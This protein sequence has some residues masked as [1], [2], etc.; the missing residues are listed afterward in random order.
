MT[1]ENWFWLVAVALLGG[2]IGSFL[3]VVIYRLARG[4][5]VGRPAR[6]FCPGCHATIAWYDNIPLFSY[7][8]LGGR[9][10]RCGMVISA[11]YPLVEGLTI[12]LFLLMY[13]TFFLGPAR[14]GFTTLRDDWPIFLAHLVLIA[15]LLVTAAIDME[16]YWIDVTVTYVVVGAGILLHG[17]WTPFR[18]AVIPRPGPTTAAVAAA[19]ALGL[20]LA[21]LWSRR[22]PHAPGSEIAEDQEEHDSLSEPSAPVQNRRTSL[23]CAS[24]MVIVIAVWF[25]LL[26]V[27]PHGA[28]DPG[29]FAIRAVLAIA[30]AFSLMVAAGMTPTE[31]DREIIEAINEER[32]TARRMVLLEMAWLLPAIVLGVVACIVVARTAAGAE[33]WQRALNWTPRN[34]A[35]R[36]VLGVTTALGGFIVAGAVAWGV[37]I[38]F[39]LVLGKE[40]FGMGDVHLMAAA[41]AVAGWPVVVAGFFLA[42]PLA[43]AAVL[44]WLIRKRSRAVWYGPWLGLGI[45]IAIVAYE[46]IAERAR[47]SIEVILWLFG[48]GGR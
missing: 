15:G 24:L 19:A 26:A 30:A 7:L 29:G 32:I 38:F 2:C 46:P 42:A 17:L 33:L 20:L 6:S 5:S 23:A 28:A 21:V 25:A 40:A 14:P 31:A 22:R 48:H 1:R 13:D 9:C 45:V 41:G 37:R 44:I 18:H 35:W 43:L 36:P 47:A 3:N 11:R 27:S 34:G 8:M 16:G 12:L 39:T 4:M 10:R